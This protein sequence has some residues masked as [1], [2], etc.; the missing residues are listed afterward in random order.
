MLPGDLTQ[1]MFRA[2]LLDTNLQDTK[3]PPS[4]VSISYKD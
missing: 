2:T 4:L 1:D 3:D